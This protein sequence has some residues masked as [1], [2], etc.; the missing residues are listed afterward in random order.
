MLRSAASAIFLAGFVVAQGQEFLAVRDKKEKPDQA[1]ELQACGVA[2]LVN[3]GVCRCVPESTCAYCNGV[4]GPAAPGVVAAPGPVVV[5]SPPVVGGG[6]CGVAGLVSCGVCPCVPPGTCAWCDGYGGPAA[7]DSN[8]IA[9]PEIA[10]NES[11]DVMPLPKAKAAA[12]ASSS[13]GKD[14]LPL[15]SVES[16]PD[17]TKNTSLDGRHL[18]ACGVAGL[19]NCG[20]CRC[21]PESTCAYCNGV[22]GPAVPVVAAAPVPVVVVSPVVGGGACGVAGLVSCG[23]CPC[24]PPGTCAWCNGYGGPAAI[25][26]NFIALPE[27]ASNKSKDAMPLSRP[28]SPPDSTKNATLDGRHLTACGAPGLFNCGVC[29]CV[30]E[31]TCAWCNGYGGPAVPVGAAVPV[32][33]AVGAVAGAVAGAAGAVAGAV[34]GAA[35]A[36]AGAVA[37]VVGS[38]VCNADGLVT[39]GVC[40]CVPESTCAWCNGYGGPAAIGFVAIPNSSLANG[41]QVPLSMSGPQ[42][43]LNSTKTAPSNG[44]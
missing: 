23:V 43:E 16:Q 34:V 4:G 12:T 20:V 9:L 39:C 19:V 3:C 17:A 41:S 5:V 10:S 31:P 37:G 42:F 24:V 14:A 11:R 13:K 8:F 2:G 26:S 27:I 36:V 15:P 21:V 25:D 28:E 30:P 29:R 35:G 40:V 33:G 38:A 7:I 18:Q 22:G 32:V 44:H 6:A 1:R